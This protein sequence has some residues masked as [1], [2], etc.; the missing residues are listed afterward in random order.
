MNANELDE[1]ERL[2]SERDA[3]PMDDDL[4]RL[5]TSQAY[6][7]QLQSLAHD[8]IASARQLATITAERDKLRAELAAARRGRARGRGAR[9]A[10]GPRWGPDRS[11]RRRIR[12]GCGRHR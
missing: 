6:A 9:L 5:V 11:G 8:L 12:Q 4:G 7:M 10:A 2:K 1:L 3:V